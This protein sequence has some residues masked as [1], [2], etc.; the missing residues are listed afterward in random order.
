MVTCLICRGE[1]KRIT[2]FHVGTKHSIT[3]GEY[4]AKFPQAEIESQAWIEA[5]RKAHVGQ[6]AWNK[7]LNKQTNTKV[8]EYGATLSRR[9][10]GEPKLEKG[11]IY[12]FHTC[13]MKRKP[14]S[15][16]HRAKIG[17]AN[18]GK[19]K[20]KVASSL[21]VKKNPHKAVVKG[22]GVRKQRI[23]KHP[24]TA[25]PWLGKK[26]TEEQKQ[27]IAESMRRYIRELPSELQK[28][29][30]RKW[31]KASGLKPNKS[32][33]KLDALL[34]EHFPNEWK[35]GGKGEFVLGGKI[36]DFFNIN[37]KKWLIEF[38]GEFWHEGED[39]QER[40]DYFANLGFRT[41]VIWGK[42]LKDEQS[43]IGKVRNFESNT[44]GH[45]KEESLGAK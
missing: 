6:Q 8:A 29:R 28:E 36:P 27:R 39:P 9:L 40:I 23:L 31:W 30:V 5:N 24:Y 22:Q 13:E 4:R 26:H 17:Q 25:K 18:K 11:K 45:S 2:G 38:N 34:Q 19:K 10:C 16:E 1:F 3:L 32:E 44:G 7:G 33:A 42:E 12:K 20:N 35:Y 21:T 14:L 41:L 37:G 15:A 43:I